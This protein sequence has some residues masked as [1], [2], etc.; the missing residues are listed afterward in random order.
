[1]LESEWHAAAARAVHAC[2]YRDLRIPHTG[3]NIHFH[4]FLSLRLTL[5]LGQL[6]KPKEI[7]KILQQLNSNV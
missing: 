1:M 5:Y 3:F 7:Y 6:K 2:Y 4:S